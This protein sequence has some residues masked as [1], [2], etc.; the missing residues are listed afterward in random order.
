MIS[1]GRIVSR[2]TQ[3]HASNA[4]TITM[5]MRIAVMAASP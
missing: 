1:D 2:V 4:L 5:V 3:S